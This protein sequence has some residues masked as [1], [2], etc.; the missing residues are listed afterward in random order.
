MRRI[1]ILLMP[2]FLAAF[3]TG[4]AAVAASAQEYKDKTLTFIVGYSPGGSFDLYARVIARHI[5]KYFAR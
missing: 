5:G 1:M 3:A 2:L 4:S